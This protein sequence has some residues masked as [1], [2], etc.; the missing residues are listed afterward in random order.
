M[1][2]PALWPLRASERLCAA[3]SAL[4]AATAARTAADAALTVAI[5]G[6]WDTVGMAAIGHPSL[7]EPTR[8]ADLARAAQ[9]DA[10][11]AWRQALEDELSLREADSLPP[12]A[13]ARLAAR[14][15]VAS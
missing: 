2:L 15:W 13:R 1:T 14:T 4:L 12:A 11:R 7:T 3:A 10:D 9:G 8:T 6:L 5:L